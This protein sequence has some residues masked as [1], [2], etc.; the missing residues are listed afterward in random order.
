[1]TITRILSRIGVN[2]RA[3]LVGLIGVVGLILV[4]VVYYLA[5]RGTITL[6]VR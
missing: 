5:S 3:G 6:D 4:G 1:L 2:Y